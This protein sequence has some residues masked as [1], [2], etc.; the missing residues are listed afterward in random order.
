ML[1]TFFFVLFS[2]QRVWEK[3]IEKYETTIFNFN[4]IFLVILKQYDSK[5]IRAFQVQ[6]AMSDYTYNCSK[7]LA[8]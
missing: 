7:P 3:T 2:G 1:P 4:T 8:T 6:D 5:S